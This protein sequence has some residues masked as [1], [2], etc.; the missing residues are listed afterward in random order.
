MINALYVLILTS[1]ACGL[2]G[3]FLNLRKLSMLTDAISHTVLLGIVLAYFIVH[4]LDSP[5]LVIGATLMGV[6]TVILVEALGK[7]KLTKYED[8]IGVIFPLLFSLAVILI[9]RYFRGV[10]LDT[11]VVLLGE[12]IFSSMVKIN[13]FGFEISKA[14]VSSMVLLFIVLAFILIFYKE[15]KVSTFDREYAKLIG[16]PVGF[17]F[18][19]LMTLTSFTAVASFNSVGAILVISFFIAPSATSLLITRHLHTTLI[20]VI[21]ISIINCTLA[22]YLAIYF[23]ASIAGMC[24]FINMVTFLSVL[25]Y[26]KY[27]MARRLK[28]L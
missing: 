6:V 19:A 12:V 2:L 9:S 22:Y 3:V 1:I 13:V 27:R 4:D 5:L 28:T 23:N 16:I 18:Y 7:S 26:N 15:L 11:D 25:I 10:H 21:I 8:A 20:S 14:L 24:A 17:L